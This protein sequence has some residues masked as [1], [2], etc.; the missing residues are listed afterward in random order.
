MAGR[1]VRRHGAHDAGP[2][3]H[4][5]RHR[6]VDLHLGAGPVQR[7]S[8]RPQRTLWEH[9]LQRGAVLEVPRRAVRQ[10]HQSSPSA[11]ATS[12]ASGGRTPST[13]TT[14]PTSSSSRARRSRTSAAAASTPRSTTSRSPTPPRTTTSRRSRHRGGALVLHRRGTGLRPEQLRVGADSRAA[15][16]TS[17]RAFRVGSLEHRLDYGA[18]YRGAEV[19][20]CPASARS[21]TSTS[22]GQPTSYSCSLGVLGLI[23]IHG[24][25]KVYDVDKKVGTTGTGRTRRASRTQPYTRVIATFGAFHG[26]CARELRLPLRLTTIDVD[27]PLTMNR[28][29]RMAADRPAISPSPRWRRRLRHRRP[30]RFADCAPTESFQVFVG[31]A[32]RRA[33]GDGARDARDPPRPATLFARARRARRGRASDRGGV[34][35]RRPPAT[36]SIQR[37]DAR[38]DQILLF[39]RSQS[40]A[41]AVGAATRFAIDAARSGSVRRRGARCIAPRH[42]ELRGRRRRT[43]LRRRRRARARHPRRRAAQRCDGSARGARRSERTDLDRRRPRSQPSGSSAATATRTRNATSFA[44]QRRRRERGGDWDTVRAAVLASRRARTHDRAGRRRG[45]G[46]ARRDRRPRP[47]AASSSWPRARL[48]R[49]RDASPMRSRAPPIA[50]AAASASSWKRH[51]LA[52]ATRS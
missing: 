12:S 48:R 37:G 41:N 8:G 25:G 18:L 7:L 32:G 15:T 46:P 3:L 50:P 21:C 10:R 38:P 36:A 17:S 9:Q 27:F 40:M 33:A 11:A 29:P 49:C 16:R 42:R 24:D 5:H 13:T 23:L 26:A 22:T 28:S 39:D 34:G 2:D 31:P 14:R 4:R 45:S 47:T 30:G 19:D 44:A 35:A 43:E 20:E 6:R 51:P 52:R 1:G